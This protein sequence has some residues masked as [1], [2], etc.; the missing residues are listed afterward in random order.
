MSGKKRA[1]VFPALLLNNGK[2]VK[3]VKFRE[4]KYLGDPIN[5]LRVFNKKRVDEMIIIDYGVSSP[6]FEFIRELASECFMPVTY[7]GGVRSIWD[8]AGLIE[9]GVDKVCCNTLWW[10]APSKMAEINKEFGSS[11]MVASIDLKTRWLRRRKSV[12]G[13]RR[14]TLSA[15]D[16][17]SQCED[18]GFGEIL[19]TDVDRE[20]TMIGFDSNL[21]A[22]LTEDTTVPVIAM[23]GGATYADIASLL[24]GCGIDGVA[25]GSL[26][27]YSG[28]HKAVL[29]NYPSE[30]FIDSIYG[31][32]GVERMS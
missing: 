14:G 1:R 7:G 5:A 9:A 12:F 27:A 32:N 2:F 10:T 17:L 25:C 3:T 15:G 6:N 22:R 24:A 4:E 23:G 18:L 31:G 29:I 26:F 19:V 28:P 11:T 13:P 21:F 8:V 20:G 16:A 30:V